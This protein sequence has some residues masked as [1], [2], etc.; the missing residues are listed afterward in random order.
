MSLKIPKSHYCFRLLQNLDD[1]FIQDQAWHHSQSIP[2]SSLTQSLIYRHPTGFWWWKEADRLSG[3]A[4]NNGMG[5]CFIPA[6]SASALGSQK[7]KCTDN[8]SQ[9]YIFQGRCMKRM[10]KANVFGFFFVSAL[11]SGAE[12]LKIWAENSQIFLLFQTMPIK[13]VLFCI[14]VLLSCRQDDLLAKEDK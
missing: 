2:V 3:T 11:F 10:N 5:N 13:I 9:N 12:D 4:V 6:V 7:K 1:S 8:K 14:S